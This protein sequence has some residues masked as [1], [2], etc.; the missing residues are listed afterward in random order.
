MEAYQSIQKIIKV[1]DEGAIIIPEE[2]MR[3]LGLEIGDEVKVII[4]K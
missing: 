3:R 2:E 4:S 1:G